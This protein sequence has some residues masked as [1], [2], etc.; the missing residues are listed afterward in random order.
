MAEQ[1]SAKEAFS[2]NVQFYKDHDG[3]YV[4]A[5]DGINHISTVIIKE[6]I[7]NEIR[8]Y[9][10]MLSE[11]GKSCITT[12]GAR[13]SIHEKDSFHNREIELKGK[14]FNMEIEFISPKKVFV[15]NIAGAVFHF[16][17]KPYFEDVAR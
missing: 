14:L 6:C 9:R 1:L 13:V 16:L 17:N 7:E 4:I 12:L 11:Q 5:I 10:Q 3:K 2:T 8:K 15:R